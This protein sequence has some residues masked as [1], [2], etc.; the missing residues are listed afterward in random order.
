[1][2]VKRATADYAELQK[3]LYKSSGIYY[4]AEESNIFKG[5]A[6]IFGPKDTPYED[7]PML[8]EITIPETYPFE[9]PIVKF[10][11][12]YQRLRFHPNM[13]VD[14]K[15]C[16]S[17][18]GTWQGPKWA[19][20]M[21]IS[22]VLVTLQSLM[23]DTPLRH[24]PVFQTIDKTDPKSIEYNTLVEYACIHYILERAEAI[25]YNKVQPISFGPFLDIFQNR[26]LETL[27]RLQKRLAN[28][29]SNPTIQISK[30]PYGVS[31]EIQWSQTYNRLMELL[32]KM[33]Q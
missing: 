10:C 3:D 18:L 30:A 26:L 12:Q 28:L 19:S 21:R 5:Y 8:Y 32:S 25:V 7:C 1:M 9:P 24:E 2:A 4:Y 29:Q 15:C 31:I 16:L 17:I 27:E 11:S 20:T 22:T 23:D 6:C 14:G 33:G 13:Y